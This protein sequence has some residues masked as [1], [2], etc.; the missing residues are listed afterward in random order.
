MPPVPMR[1][2]AF[3]LSGH[4]CSSGCNLSPM[5]N[6]AISNL[7]MALLSLMQRARGLHA[8]SLSAC[9]VPATG[10]VLPNAVLEGVLGVVVDYGNLKLQ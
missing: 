6:R 5:Q 10:P 4:S 2:T 8:G 9:M 3:I 1:A 7:S